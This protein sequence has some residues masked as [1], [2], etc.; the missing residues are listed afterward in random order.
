[1]MKIYINIHPST[2]KADSET[3]IEHSPHSSDV[4]MQC[5]MLKQTTERILWHQRLN[6]CSDAYLYEAHKNIHG[7]PKFKRATPVMDQCPTCLAAKIRKAPRTLSPTRR[8]VVCS[9]DFGFIGASK[10]D[11]PKQRSFEGL[12]GETCHLLVTDHFTG[13]LF[14]TPKESRVVPLDYL[15]RLFQQHFPR[16]IHDR[17]TFAFVMLFRDA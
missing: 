4:P 8:A 9:I 5:H 14:G 13:E 11:S 3:M 17:Y 7:V 1:M 6:H 16:N 2:H 12:Y 15:E 10:K